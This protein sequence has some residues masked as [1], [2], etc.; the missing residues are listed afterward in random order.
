MYVLTTC[1][2]WFSSSLLI[3]WRILVL[4]FSIGSPWDQI[5]IRKV[6]SLSLNTEPSSYWTTSCFQK[7]LNVFKSSI[8]QKLVELTFANANTLHVM[9]SATNFWTELFAIKFSPIVPTMQITKVANILQSIFVEMPMVWEAREIIE[10]SSSLY[11][12]Q[13]LTLS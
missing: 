6:F 9:Y 12:W 13:N 3:C 10:Q 7:V 5:S 1:T 8:W 4:T 2:Y 11:H